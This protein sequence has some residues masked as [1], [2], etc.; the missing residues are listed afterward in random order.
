MEFIWSPPIC[1]LL[2]VVIIAVVLIR[3]FSVTFFW[4][5][6]SKWAFVPALVIIAMLCVANFAQRARRYMAA[7]LVVCYLCSIY[8]DGWSTIVMRIADG[9]SAW[10]EAIEAAVIAIF[11]LLSL[12]PSER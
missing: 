10:F 3:L 6:E 9:G 7:A 8:F 2:C 1:A 5:T 12:L 11:A 4:T